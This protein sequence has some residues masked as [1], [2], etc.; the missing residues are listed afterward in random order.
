MNNREKL[1]AWLNDKHGRRMALSRKL[2]IRVEYLAEIVK[3]GAGMTDNEYSG[4][5]S[6]MQDVEQDEID[7]QKERSKTAKDHVRRAQVLNWV[8]KRCLRMSRL[9]DGL[10]ISKTNLSL[11]VYKRNYLNDYSDDVWVNYQNTMKTIE[12]IE[13]FDDFMG[14]LVTIWL[15]NEDHKNLL[16]QLYPSKQSLI[17][18][19]ISPDG[20]S[21]NICSRLDW[22]EIIEIMNSIQF[23]NAQELKKAG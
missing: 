1:E 3:H 14:T 19:R 6:L 15:W 11:S 13:R 16:R 20:K 22:S 17:H 2:G 23:T 7:K 8:K 9:S 12:E 18:L 10:G 5:V 21:R 4:Y